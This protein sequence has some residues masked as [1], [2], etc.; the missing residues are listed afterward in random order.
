MMAQAAGK[1]LDAED[2]QRGKAMLARINQ[3]SFRDWVRPGALALI[4]AEIRTSRP[5]FATALCRVDIEGKTVCSA[6]LFFS[7]VPSSQFTPGYRDE[8]LERY[9]TDKSS[10]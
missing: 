4:F 2:T 6:E 7:F 3:A 9:R 8:I 10:S 5:Q 1:C